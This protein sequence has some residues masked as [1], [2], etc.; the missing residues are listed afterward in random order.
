MNAVRLDTLRIRDLLVRC[1]VGVTAPE[2]SKPQDILIT[3]T[4]YADLRKACRSDRLR[5]SVDYK[6]IKQRILAETETKAFHLIERLAERV[7]AIC[8]RAPRVECVEVTVQKPGALRF[9]RCSEVEIM[10]ARGKGQGAAGE[11][12]DE[13]RTGGTVDQGTA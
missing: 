3:I 11:R 13:Q 8:L 10:R 12:Q 6:A 9:A 2:R 4:L 5:D 7:A 1:R